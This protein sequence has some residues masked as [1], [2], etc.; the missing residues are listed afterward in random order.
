MQLIKISKAR[1]RSH[2]RYVFIA[3]IALLAIGSLVISQTLIAFF[4]NEDGSHFHWNLSGVMLTSIFIAWCLNKSRQH[5]FMLEVVYVWELKQALN[6]ITRKMH[7]IKKSAKKGDVN[8]L[9]ALQ[10]SYAGSRLLWE[11]DDNAIVMDELAIEQLALDTLMQ[12]YQLSIDPNNY[13]Q[14]MLDAF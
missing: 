7:N 8:A 6:K 2:L 10:F 11:L 12:K 14:S 4:P 5:P 1:Y 9:T 3:C 13:T